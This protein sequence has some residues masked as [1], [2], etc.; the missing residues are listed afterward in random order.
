MA[1]GRQATQLVTLVRLKPLPTPCSQ[2]A[3]V[4]PSC[5]VSPDRTQG[6][7]AIEIITNA[8]ISIAILFLMPPKPLRA[9]NL[10]VA[11]RLVSGYVGRDQGH[12]DPSASYIIQPSLPPHTE[13][14][15]A[16]LS[17]LR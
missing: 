9:D 4:S 15:L 6:A 3:F 11:S 12:Y 13:T 8:N 16:M 10:K 5:G 1:H 2:L 7:A 14:A 17:L